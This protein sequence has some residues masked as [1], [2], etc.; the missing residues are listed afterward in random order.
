MSLSCSS[1]EV[2]RPC[3]RR[4]GE[5]GTW[6]GRTVV[7]ASGAE[8]SH[9]RGLPLHYYLTQRDLQTFSTAIRL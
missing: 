4:L 8:L 2:F 5:Q 3:C 9:H 1:Q 6:M 7:N